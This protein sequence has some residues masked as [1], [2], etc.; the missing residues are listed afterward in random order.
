MRDINGLTLSC[1]IPELYAPWK[2]QPGFVA[3][4]IERIA[5]EGVFRSVELSP[6]QTVEDREAIR[7]TCA[8]HGIEVSVWLTSVLEWDGHDV[9]AVDEAARQGAVEAVRGMLGD[10]VATGAKTVALVG[11]AD[12][13]PS[14]RDKGYDAC[15]KSLIEI[16]RAAADHGLSVMMEPLDRFAHKKRLVGPTDETVALFARVRAECPDFGFAFDTAHAALNGEDVLDAIGL[17]SAQIV[18]MHLSNAVLEP[19]DR[20]YGD[21]HMMPG[22]PGFLTVESAGAIVARTAQ[23]AREN[24]NPIRLAV[25]ARAPATAREQETAELSHAFLSQVLERADAMLSEQA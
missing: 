4:Q 23:V 5:S 17:A 21:H 19:S 9:C 7:A 12:P 16:G 13:G 15:C 10:A 3:R 2:D 20:L 1:L 11:G 6:V 24:G 22:S 8:A 25:E 14:L 18:N